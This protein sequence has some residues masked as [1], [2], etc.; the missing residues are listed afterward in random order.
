MLTR[1]IILYRGL[2][3][4]HNGK[5]FETFSLRLDGLGFKLGSFIFT[6]SLGS[7]IHTIKKSKG[8]GKK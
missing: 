2:I 3:N 6:K 8:K 4:V 1:A 5:S 7:K